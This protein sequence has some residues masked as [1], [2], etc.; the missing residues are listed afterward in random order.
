[1]QP[2]QSGLRE[3][4]R[5]TS[6]G[7]APTKR[8]AHRHRPCR[9]M[10]VAV[11]RTGALDACSEVIDMRKRKSRNKLADYQAKRDFERTGEPRGGDVRASPGRLR[12]VIQKHAARR[13]H[14]DLRLELDG[15]FKSWAVTKG[16]SLDP[17]DKRLA[18]QVEDHP[19]DYG[20]FEGTIPRGEYGGGTVQIWDRGYW[21]PE[22]GEDAETG[23]AKG[24]LKFV[25]AGARLN[26]GWVL[27]RMKR[28]PREK[29]DN[30]LLI[31]HR[32]AY[33][34]RDGEALLEEDASVASGRPMDEIAAGKGRRPKPF[35]RRS[36]SRADA[37]WH[38]NRAEPRA[39]SRKMGTVPISRKLG[40]VPVSTTRLARLPE[41][42]EPQ[43]CR[44]VERAP[45]GPGWGHEVKL[46]GYR[47]QMRV[48]NGRVRLLTRK[49]LDWTDRFTR[50]AA[51]GARLPNAHIDG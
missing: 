29:R 30:W 3:L 35:M 20:D 37:V 2:L 26:G 42:V 11:F 16:P 10:L 17:G 27:V 41:F 45:S 22:P 5:A 18:V 44:L 49:G 19:L 32:D 34:Q 51:A 21:A 13:L 1:V 6:I 40:T 8:A 36:A 9:G 43:L 7:I 15:V 47:I 14:Y 39:A 48:E 31:K 25:L 28:R 33:A 50:I 23:L 46:D 38:S 4:R 24:S 12:Y